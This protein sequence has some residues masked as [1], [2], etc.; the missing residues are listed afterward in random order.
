MMGLETDNSPIDVWLS[1]ME[2][3]IENIV[4]FAIDGN[5]AIN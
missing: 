1:K 2:A 5:L 3:A 4:S